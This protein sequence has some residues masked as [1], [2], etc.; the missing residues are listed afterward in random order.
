MIKLPENID[1]VKLF[2]TAYD[3]SRPQGLGFLNFNPKPLS[4][5][6]AEAIV[7]DHKRPDGSY[8]FDYVA[9]RALKF[10]IRKEPDGY[11]INNPWYD[12]TDASL[13]ELLRTFDISMGETKEHGCACACP[14]C[15]K[16]DY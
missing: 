14:M 15:E 4:R 3:L 6:A 7:N 1:I 2:M 5:S 16:D 9:G 11:S 8:Y 10:S 12:H 13:R